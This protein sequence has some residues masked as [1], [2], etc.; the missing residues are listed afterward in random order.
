MEPKPEEPGGLSERSA[1]GTC[2]TN[3]ILYRQFH[4]YQ[5]RKYIKRGIEDWQIAFEKAGFKNAIIAIV[6]IVWNRYG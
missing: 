2:Q 4:T 6:T 1:C 5:W 3:R